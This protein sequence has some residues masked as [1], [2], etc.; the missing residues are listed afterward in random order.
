M[1]RINVFVQVENVN[2]SKVIELAGELVKK[3]VKEE[4]CIAYDFFESTTREGVLMF[5][6]TWKDATTLA[7][8]EKTEHFVTILPQIQALST[9][10]V[11]KFEF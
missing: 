7:A 2:R 4:G 6:E 10:K 9:A 1:I 11:E 5:C 8:H 3:S